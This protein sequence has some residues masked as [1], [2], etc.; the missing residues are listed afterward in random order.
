M[1]FI[2]VSRLICSIVS[3]LTFYIYFIKIF[4]SFQSRSLTLARLCGGLGLPLVFSI[5]S[6]APAIEKIEGELL[7]VVLGVAVGW[8]GLIFQQ[9]PLRLFLL[10]FYIRALSFNNLSSVGLLIFNLSAISFLF[11]LLS[12]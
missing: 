10:N 9:P 8:S 4:L 2:F 6:S 1:L 12:L 11:I 3:F 5:N 7:A